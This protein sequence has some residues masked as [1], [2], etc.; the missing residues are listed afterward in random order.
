MVMEAGAAGTAGQSL[1]FI[2]SISGR[3]GEDAAALADLGERAVMAVA[4]AVDPPS[5]SPTSCLRRPAE[6]SLRSERPG[7]EGVLREI[8]VRQ[9]R[10]SKRRGLLPL[11]EIAEGCSPRVSL[12]DAPD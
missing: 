7:P 5:E 9:V 6:T 1:L 3:I 10:A 2:K 8:L 12:L 4:A 11:P